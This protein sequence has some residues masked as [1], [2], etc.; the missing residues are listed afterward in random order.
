VTFADPVSGG[1]FTQAFVR[2]CNYEFDREPDLATSLNWRS[3]EGADERLLEA[4]RD[5]YGCPVHHTKGFIGGS[6]GFLPIPGT[7]IDRD[8]D[9]FVNWLK[10]TEFNCKGQLKILYRGV[11][12]PIEAPL[13]AEAELSE[14]KLA[15]SSKESLRTLYLLCSFTTKQGPGPSIGRIYI[16]SAN[17]QQ[18]LAYLKGRKSVGDW[19]RIAKNETHA[20][21]LAT[22]E[23]R[24]KYIKY[25]IDPT[26]IQCEC[27]WQSE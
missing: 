22:R 13:I 5:P 9:G 25:G 8:T 24:M 26:S 18:A 12:A 11:N 4:L 14:D 20:R 7:K 15:V 23:L 1:Y 10:F 2:A 3:L 27:H 17:E 6:S 19:Y 21:Q 16:V